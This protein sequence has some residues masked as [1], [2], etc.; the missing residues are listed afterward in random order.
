MLAFSQDLLGERLD[1]G[2]NFFFGLGTGFFRKLGF[3]LELGDLLLR[4]A[5]GFLDVDIGICRPRKRHQ[6]YFFE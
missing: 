1:R 3:F 4:L 6:Q 2:F 5:T